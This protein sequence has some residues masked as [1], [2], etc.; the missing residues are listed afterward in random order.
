MNLSIRVG[1]FLVALVPCGFASCEPSGQRVTLNERV[2]NIPDMT[3]FAQGCS[4]YVLS[5][6]GGQTASGAG[7][8]TSGLAVEESSSG[9]R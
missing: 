9:A 2:Y 7:S 4:Y 8:A 1:A 5:D 6:N 3:L